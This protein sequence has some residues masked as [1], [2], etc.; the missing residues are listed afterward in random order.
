MS[1]LSRESRARLTT[2]VASLRIP[3]PRPPSAAALENVGRMLTSPNDLND[4]QR[5]RLLATH[6]QL[7]DENQRL[8]AILAATN[9]GVERIVAG[10]RDGNAARKRSPP[11]LQSPTTASAGKRA[12]HM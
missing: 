1:F 8:R 4:A 6:L 9:V 10:L 12:R 3:L 2:D 7:V 11:P 5:G